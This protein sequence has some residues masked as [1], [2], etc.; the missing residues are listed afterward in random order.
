MHGCID[1]I[2]VQAGAFRKKTV[3]KSFSESLNALLT[4]L[5]PRKHNWV[6]CLKPNQL[7]R[8]GIFDTEFMQSQ[9]AYSGTLEMARLRK[10]GFSDRRPLDAVW[11][12]YS[13]ILQD[14]QGSAERGR[15]LRKELRDLPDDKKVARLL[16][17]TDIPEL[18][19]RI[20]RTLLFLRDG[21]LRRL[22]QAHA[23]ALRH[24]KTRAVATCKMWLIRN[25]RKL[26]K[27]A[28]K[29]AHGAQDGRACARL[30]IRSEEKVTITGDGGDE[31]IMELFGG[32]DPE[33]KELLK[34]AAEVPTER[35]GP[36]L[37]GADP[38]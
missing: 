29:A 32:H 37:N 4:D 7:L 8:P 24:A 31:V 25:R 11:R 6:R 9:L 19:Y 28:L 2:C 16:A 13:I 14:T 36:L 22:D 18:Y 38:Y 3:F 5:I 23:I 34:L 12:Y 35:G 33:L 30:F 17:E 20:G 21:M 10:N 26:L 15:Q 1:V 27:A